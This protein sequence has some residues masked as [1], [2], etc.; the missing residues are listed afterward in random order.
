LI[1]F[2]HGHYRFQNKDF[3]CVIEIFQTE[4]AYQELNSRRDGFMV[5]YQYLFDLQQI[6]HNTSSSLT[7]QRFLGDEKTS[8]HIFR[9]YSLLEIT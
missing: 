7:N 3:G 6:L 5:S 4:I 8:S 9:G 1:L 2:N